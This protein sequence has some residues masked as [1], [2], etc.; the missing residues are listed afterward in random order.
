MMEEGA[1]EESDKLDMQRNRKR[2]TKDRK[3]GK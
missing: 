2:N 1:W 3:I